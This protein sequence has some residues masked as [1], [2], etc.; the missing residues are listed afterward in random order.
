MAT[1]L[2]VAVTMSVFV[3]VFTAAA[4]AIL[5]V[6]VTM[7]VFVAMSAASAFAVL[8]MVVSVAV[9]AMSMSATF[10]LLA[11]MSATTSSVAVLMTASAAFAAHHVDKALDF[12]ISCRPGFYHV[13]AEMQGPSRQEVVQVDHYGLFLHLDDDAVKAIA[14][15]IGQGDDVSGVDIVLVK[16]SVNTEDLLVEFQD[17][18][19]FVR[20]VGFVHAQRE[21]KSVSLF[22]GH[23]MAFESIEHAAEARDELQRV[24][25]GSFFDEFMYAF[26]IVGVEFVCHG[27]ILVG[28]LFHLR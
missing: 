7:S 3:A 23:D 27:D 11:V 17:V 28:S 20:A 16:A 15:L 4:S 10:A 19:L 22:K 21:V 13:A 1:A 12:G 18:A 9:F 25:G 26:G 24:L 6:L 5:A 14:V 8:V 2:A